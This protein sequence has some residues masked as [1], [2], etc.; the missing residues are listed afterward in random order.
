MARRLIP[1]LN[2]VLV[3]KLV[4]PKKSPAGILLPETTK[5]VPP[6]IDL[7]LF[8]LVLFPG[9]V[10]SW[11]QYASGPGIWCCRSGSGSCG[12]RV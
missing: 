9:L 2:R 5:Q 8:L 6:S 7:A 10:P 1:S 11:P 3:E 4:Q 12:L